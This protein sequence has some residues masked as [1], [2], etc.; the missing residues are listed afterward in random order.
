MTASTNYSLD[1]H[2]I[3]R[4]GTPEDIAAAVAYL[5]SPSSGFVTGDTLKVDGGTAIG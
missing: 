4:M 5:A 3:K 1:T 2:A